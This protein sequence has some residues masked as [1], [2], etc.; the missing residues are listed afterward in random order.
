MPSAPP[1]GRWVAGIAF[2][3]QDAPDDIYLQDVIT[4]PGHRQRGITRMLI[5]TVADRGRDWECRRLYLTSEPENRAA[6]ATWIT[7]GF[8]NVPG[9]HTIDEVSVI[10]DY[11]GPGKTR[12]V[13]DPRR[14]RNAAELNGRPRNHRPGP[15]STAAPKGAGPRPHLDHANPH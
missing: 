1:G 3:S 9:D 6:H 12:A 4:H 13:Q 5:N 15:P 10:T 11:K 14:L 8:T 2:R 7:L